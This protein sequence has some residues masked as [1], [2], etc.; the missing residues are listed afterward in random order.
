M[1]P[2]LALLAILCLPLSGAAADS[3][4]TVRVD[5]S[6]PALS[7]SSWTLVLRPDGSGHFSSHPGE[8]S[9]ENMEPPAINR[10]IQL[11][12]AF[13]DQVFAAA[14]SRTVLKDNCESHSKVA[15]QGWKTITYQD[16]D[17]QGTCKFNFSKNRQ[18]QSLSDA[19]IAVANTVVEG[20][21]LEMLL[22]H[23][24][25]GLDKEMGFLIEASADGR[26]RQICAIRGILERLASDQT[27]MDRVR[28]RARTL[29]ARA[30]KGD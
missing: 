29:L 5:Y 23:D 20:E 2:F 1:K 17:T 26:V 25:L 4:A 3:S 10:P 24:P 9:K 28:K 27:V 19:L 11:N 6:N 21:R 13:A 22:E 14:S 30:E 15:F 7:P 16:G 8:P 18:I 12:P